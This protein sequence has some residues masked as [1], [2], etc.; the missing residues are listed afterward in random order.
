MEKMGFTQSSR[1]A[2]NLMKQLNS[3]KSNKT[4]K[5]TLI[6]ADIVAKQIKE[7]GLHT[8]RHKFEQNVRH[9]FWKLYHECPDADPLL[10]GS[11]GTNKIELAIDEI[12]QGKSTGTDNI[13]PE[14][15]KNLGD[16]ALAWLAGCSNV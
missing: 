3:D 5:Q 8:P 15:M 7:R 1:H 16:I 2:W 11:E 9:E 10:T 6:S 13:C 4:E 14:M 12:K